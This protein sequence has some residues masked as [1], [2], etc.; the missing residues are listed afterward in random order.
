MSPESGITKIIRKGTEHLTLL[1]F[2]K[3]TL[4]FEG[5]CSEIKIQTK[6]SKQSQGACTK[7]YDIHL[8]STCNIIEKQPSI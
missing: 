4:K 8:R 3:C 6:R 2:A 5:E 7:L 1:T